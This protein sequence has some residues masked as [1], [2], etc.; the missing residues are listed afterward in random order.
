MGVIPVVPSNETPPIFT[1]AANAVAVAAL[2]DTLPVKS[3]VIVPPTVKFPLKLTSP[4]TSNSTDGFV[5][6]I[7]TE[8]LL[9]ITMA[10]L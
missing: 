6:P 5:L 9:Q 8:L 7:P 2:P 4:L 10:V 3:P 1:D